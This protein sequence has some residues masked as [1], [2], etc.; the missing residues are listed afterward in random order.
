M[1]VQNRVLRVLAMLV[2]LL[3]LLIFASEAY[4]ALAELHGSR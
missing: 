3:M 2:P 1:R 4:A